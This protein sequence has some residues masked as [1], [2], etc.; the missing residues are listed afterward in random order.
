MIQKLVH[1][2]ICS[3][4]TIRRISGLED[5]FIPSEQIE[6][7]DVIFQTWLASDNVSA[8]KLLASGIFVLLKKSK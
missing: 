4:M 3:N 5:D 8:K 2:F 6:L 7:C 1:L